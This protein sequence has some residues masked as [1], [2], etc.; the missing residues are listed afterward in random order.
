MILVET[1]LVVWGEY[2]IGID[3]V[4]NSQV[5]KWFI[6]TVWNIFFLSLS[7]RV[8]GGDIG[9]LFV[10]IIF[11]FRLVNKVGI[12]LVPDLTKSAGMKVTT[13]GSLAVVDWY[14]ILKHSYKSG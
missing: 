7:F 10:L 3:V 2:G 13:E 8:V 4:D 6:S 12:V 5:S 1:I 9:E 11:W 14:K